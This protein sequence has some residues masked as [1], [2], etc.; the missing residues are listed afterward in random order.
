MA[1]ETAETYMYAD[2]LSC[3]SHAEVI[4]GEN[5]RLKWL[6]DPQQ[7][8]SVQSAV[9]IVSYVVCRLQYLLIADLF[10]QSIGYGKHL[11]RR[12]LACLGGDCFMEGFQQELNYGKEEF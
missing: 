5:A 8:F 1:K 6:P 12:K 9:A 11:F 10:Q 3:I 2:L 4:E 7:C